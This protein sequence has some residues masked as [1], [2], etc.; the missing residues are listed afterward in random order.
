MTKKLTIRE[1]EILAL[2]RYSRTEIS[3]ILGI[4]IST[5]NVHRM[6]IFQKLNAMNLV[7]AVIIAL[8]KGVIR[9]DDINNA[10][11]Y[12]KDFVAKLEG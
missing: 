9:L 7:D 12:I 10:K 1:L 6:H 8:N 5:I 2:S 11:Q 4:T 3:E